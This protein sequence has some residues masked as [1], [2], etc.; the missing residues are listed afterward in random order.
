[1]D[2]ARTYS[3]L[4]GSLTTLHTIGV[5]G[6]LT[7]GQLL[8]RFLDRRDPADSDTAFR[9][10]IERYGS[11]VLNVCRQRLGDAGDVQDAFQATFLLLVRKAGYIR[12]RG[13]LGGW[14]FVTARRVAERARSAA[15]RRREVE[16]VLGIRHQEERQLA[17]SNCRTFDESYWCS[18]EEIERLPWLFRDPLLLHYFEAQTVD[19]IAHRLGCP[20]GTVLSRL[21]R[22]RYTAPEATRAKGH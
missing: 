17:A 22:V 18:H 15:A 3:G 12:E 7:D 2:R 11:M 16:Q 9:V 21:A 4:A 13:S 10:L 6:S 1:M 14:L 8:E 5:A 20:R 19:A